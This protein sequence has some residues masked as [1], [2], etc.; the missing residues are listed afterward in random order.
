MKR[1]RTDKNNKLK[2]CRYLFFHIQL[3]DGE[4]TTV[5]IILFIRFKY[6][7]YF[8]GRMNINARTNF[9]TQFRRRQM[10]LHNKVDEFRL[11]Q[12]TF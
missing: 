10:S 3:I 2:M 11:S 1:L 6:N 12:Y 9:A 4:V 8:S 5:C 7:K